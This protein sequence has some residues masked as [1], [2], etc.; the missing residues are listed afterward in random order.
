MVLFLVPYNR[1]LSYRT[2]KPAELVAEGV[3]ISQPLSMM[4]GLLLSHRS[5]ESII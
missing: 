1:V 2:V 4:S 5:I 3:H